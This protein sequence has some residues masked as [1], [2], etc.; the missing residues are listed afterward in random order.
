MENNLTTPMKELIKQF[1]SE[2][3]HE[4][5]RPGLKYAIAIAKS[6][7]NKEKELMCWFAQEWHELKTKNNY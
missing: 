4:S 5:T 7:L 2:L 3:Q 1:E 6:M